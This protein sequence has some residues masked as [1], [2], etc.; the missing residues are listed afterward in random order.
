MLRQNQQN[1]NGLTEYLQRKTPQLRNEFGDNRDLW[2][3]IKGEVLSIDPVNEDFSNQPFDLSL[4][5]S[6]A[7]AILNTISVKSDSNVPVNS[8]RFRIR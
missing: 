7:E 2:L 4:I 6:K 5:K 1:S 3:Q 8:V